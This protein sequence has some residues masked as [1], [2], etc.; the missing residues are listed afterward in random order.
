MKIK[1]KIALRYSIVTAILMAVFAIVVYLFSSHDREVEF[2]DDLY[3]EGISKANL[4]FEAKASAE[5]MHSIY[6]NNIEYID[7]VEVAIYDTNFNLLYHDAKDIDIVKETPELIGNVINSGKNVNFYVDKYQAV[8]FIFLHHNSQYAITAAAYDG[9]GYSK[10]QRLIINLIVLTLVCIILSFIIG[11]FLA[12]RALKPVSAIS[13]RMKDITAKNLHLRLLNYNERDEFGELAASF[14]RAL[15]IIDS[16]F[17]SQKM[18]VSNVSHELQTPLAALVGEIDYALL[19]ERNISEYIATLENSKYDTLRL[20]KLVN[21]LLDLAKASYDESEISMTEIRIDE[22]ILDARENVLKMNPDYKIDI[23]FAYPTEDDKELIITGN[24]YLLRTAFSNLMENN[25]KFSEN[26]TST[27]KI[28]TENNSLSIH[29]SDSG[30]GI[31]ADDLESVF[32][33]FYRG[34]NKNFIEGNGIGLALVDRV[35]KIHKGKIEMDSV[36]SIGTVFN[37]SLFISG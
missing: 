32:K 15:D 18:F 14:N 16:S 31:S 29:F 20:I 28:F 4:F 30:I 5:T 3:K 8:G 17:E 27:V 6:K 1:T 9:Y 2:Y 26:K 35:V 37:V 12:S 19:K 24:E 33:P 34:K 11:Y 25:C 7:E 36:I 22:I 10:L 23:Q 21:G 13:D